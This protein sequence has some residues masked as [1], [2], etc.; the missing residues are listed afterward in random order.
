MNT[1]YF[2]KLKVTYIA[3]IFIATSAT[4][5]SSNALAHGDIND[6]STISTSDGITWGEVVHGG[7][8]TH[9]ALGIRIGKD[10]LH[11]LNAKRRDVEV[12]VTEGAHSPCACLAD[13]ITL[14][15]AASAG[16]RSLTIAPKASD[17]SFMTLIEIRK[18]R[19]GHVLNYRIPASAIAPL[20]N[21][22]IGKSPQE[23]F[24]LVM[25]MP[26]ESL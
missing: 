26:V 22:N 13:G 8:G 16:Q 3:I 7:F 17:D 18:K 21:M 25:A 15:T 11:R 9:I 12:T 6:S 1:K 19:T 14:V 5:A 4:L 20:G 24:D 2:P 23:R 10:A